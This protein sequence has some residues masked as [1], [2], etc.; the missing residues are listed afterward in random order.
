MSVT[1]PSRAVA[2]YCA[3]SPGND[4]AYRAAAYFLGRSLVAQNR[5]LVYGGGSKGIMGFV[6]DAVLEA[7]GNVTGVLPS[8]MLKAGGEGDKTLSKDDHGAPVVVDESKKNVQ[9]IIVNSM[10]E[11]KVEMAKRSCAFVGLPGGFGTFEEVLEA[12]TWTQLGIHD[13]P[14]ILVNVLGFWEP[15]RTLFKSSIASGFIRKDGD[16]LVIFIDGPAEHAEHASYDWG[17]EV[18]KHIE[19]WKGAPKGFYNWT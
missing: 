15:L 8:A 12:I 13:K 16:A 1:E 10:H 5:P 6:S 14:V 11:R 4:P 18:V 7:G 2:V 19:S 9:T 3:S 17:A